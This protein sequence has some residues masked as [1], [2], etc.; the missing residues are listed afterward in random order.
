MRY[1]GGEI[2][3]QYL[4]KE[5]VPYVLGIPGHGCLGLF[6]AIKKSDEAG[7]IRYLQ[8]KHEQSA[9][10]MA[11]GY[12]RVTGEPLAVLTSI[13]PGGLNTSIGLA[14]AYVDSSACM[15][16]AGD[17]HTHMRG[18]G[19]LQ[20]IERSQDSNFLRALEPVTKRCWRVEAIEQLPKIMQRSFNYMVTGR[21]GPVVVSLPMD[22]QAESMETVLPNPS[23]HK[24]SSLTSGDEAVIAQA[25]ARMK[26]AKRPVILVGG[27]VVS[28]RAFQEL[29]ELAELWGAA[30]VTTVMGKSAFP[31][32]HTLYGWHAGS[33]GT[34]VG[35]TLCSKADVVLA[36][37]VRFVDQTTSSYRK[38][39][40]F[41]FPDSTLIHVDKDYHEIGKNYPANIGIVGDLKLII[42]QLIDFYKWKARC[43]PNYEDAEYTKEILAL[44][45]AWFSSLRA[46]RQVKMDKI[47][48]SQLIDEMQKTLP[49]ETIMVTSSGNSQAQIFQE[50]CFKKPLTHIS[51][52]G[53]STMG[54]A[55]P[56]ALGVKLGKPDTPVIAVVGDGD[57]MMTMQELATAVQ[58]NIPVI[59]M[60][61]NNQGWM[62][63]K[64]LQMAVYGEDRAFGNDFVKEDGTLYSPDF[65]VIAEAFGMDGQ[66]ISKMEEVAPAL[67]KALDLSKPALIQVDL[68]REF[69]YSGGNA[70]GWWDVPVPTYLSERRE[71]YEAARSEEV[72]M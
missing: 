14:N 57:F 24:S 2:V 22:I 13:G 62:A 60:V 8:V 65:R 72:I 10:H 26:E 11:D 46:F 34:T 43:K 6:D 49:D 55:Y 48:I 70:V 41:S 66:Q 9:V 4:M 38:G 58:Y 71:R 20:E 50:Y 59:V 56:A 23:W 68:C 19:V 21:R 5:Q 45:E 3:V 67:K 17:A 47:T 42:R 25:V 37:G 16:I 61:V 32:D 18:V 12:Y 69:P 31:E 15:V 54:F 64:D 51:A 39:V 1:T 27:G 30:V 40:S 35:N 53:F 44:K 33:K 7:D 52:G 28:A 36:L 29:L 63:I